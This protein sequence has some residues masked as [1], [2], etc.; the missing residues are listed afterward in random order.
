MPNKHFVE[1]LIGGNSDKALQESEGGLTVSVD[2]YVHRHSGG[3]EGVSIHMHACVCVSVHVL[4]GP[5][6]SS[7]SLGNIF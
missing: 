2:V 4:S 3:L 7:T 5:K 6:L 1:L